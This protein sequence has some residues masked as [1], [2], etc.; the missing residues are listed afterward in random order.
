MRIITLQPSARVDHITADGQE[1]TQLP[2]PFHVRPDGEVG[3]QDFWHGEPLRVLGFQDR[4]D[5]QR[6]DLWWRD[7]A[8]DPQRAVGK[9]IVTQ[10]ADG[11][12][13]THQLAVQSVEVED[14]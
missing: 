11:S 5:V 14:R 12:M 9:Y 10:D 8:A 2:Y 4:V 6:I 7:A 3:R 1:L 13:A